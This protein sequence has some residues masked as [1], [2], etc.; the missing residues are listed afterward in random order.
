[1]T[2]LRSSGW[3]K[4]SVNQ[5]DNAPVLV[6]WQ[7]K[8]KGYHTPNGRWFASKATTTYRS[9]PWWQLS[10]SV[11]SRLDNDTTFPSSTFFFFHTDNLLPDHVIHDRMGR[12][13]RTS[14][15]TKIEPIIDRFVASSDLF[16]FV[17][18]PIRKTSNLFIFCVT[19][20]C[21]RKNFSGASVYVQV[22]RKTNRED[23]YM[24]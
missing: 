5:S 23:M 10:L 14:A 2:N 12:V 1:M 22:T 20:L 15:E 7:S 11:I 3:F 24:D 6:L 21:T 4:S 16:W 9:E 18:E 17:E 19:Y 8:M 13:M